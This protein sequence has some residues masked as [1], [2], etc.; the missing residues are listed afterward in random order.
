MCQNLQTWL[1]FVGKFR[2]THA[3]IKPPFSIRLTEK[4]FRGRSL[5]IL[6]TY[7]DSTKKQY[8]KVLFFAPIDEVWVVCR[9]SV[10]SR[11]GVIL[12][13]RRPWSSDKVLITLLWCWIQRFWK[14]R[15]LRTYVR[16]YE[17]DYFL[18]VGSRFV[19]YYGTTHVLP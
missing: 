6:R 9:C 17:Y 14:T 1:M 7:V 12:H 18:V 4:G 15:R 2:N 8:K 11:I 10:K 3:H 19:E 5:A 13:T 16:T